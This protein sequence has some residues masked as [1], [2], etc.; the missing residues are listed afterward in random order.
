MMVFL[1]SSALF[2]QTY[3]GKLENGTSIAI[4]SLVLTKKYSIQNLK[5]RLDLL[6]KLH[7]PHLVT[8]LGYCIESG[9]QEDYNVN[10]VFLVYEYVL[11]VNYRAYLSGKYVPGE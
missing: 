7:H 6:S 1:T 5:V 3:K 9:E 4:R 2:F 11:S 8:L 10:K